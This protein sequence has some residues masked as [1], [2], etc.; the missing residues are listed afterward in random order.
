M[1][2]ETVQRVALIAARNRLV[3]KTAV[4]IAT[5]ASEAINESYRQLRSRFL[6]N[7]GLGK[8]IIE[9]F[10]RIDSYVPIATTPTDGLFLAEM[11][12]NLKADGPM[13]ECGSYAG[14]SSAKLSLLAKLTDRELL[15]FDSFE[16]LPQSDAYNLKDH[17][18]RRGDR[19]IWSWD[20]GKY[21]AALDVVK[22]NIENYGEIS[23]C[24]FVKGW[25]NET[26]IDANL[27]N[28]IAFAF[29]DVD[30]ASSARECFVALWPRLRNQG[31]YVTHDT[32][33]LKVLLE[34]YN[35]DLWLNRFKEIPP[36]LF[37][38]GY[39]LCDASPHLGYM[40]KGDV[41]PEY[42]KS[43]TIKK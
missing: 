22:R 1:L 28:R 20:S 14:G 36:I 30:V 3:T 40:V 32:A 27:P 38:A 2:K 13:I 16:G 9:R 7:G 10:E 8:E 21:S 41:T 19:E 5:N 6:S 35:R 43:L 42:L 31:I 37:G 11:V 24:K 12:L 25:F 23:V 18:C 39:G 15:I 33:Y 17:H 34:L 26:L 4:Y 29:S